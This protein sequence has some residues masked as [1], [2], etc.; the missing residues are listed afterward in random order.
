MVMCTGLYLDELY[1]YVYVRV[2]NYNIDPTFTYQN[3][4]GLPADC[5]S[6][7]N[8]KEAPPFLC[9][10]LLSPKKNSPTR[11]QTAGQAA[12]PTKAKGQGDG[13][14]QTE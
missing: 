1:N 14:Q 6:K 9:P 11:S 12:K 2:Q 5:A 3:P 8:K 7:V 4:V 13:C 10:C